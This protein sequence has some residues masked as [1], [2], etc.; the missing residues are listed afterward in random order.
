MCLP[1]H[2]S[3]QGKLVK[4]FY[5]IYPSSSSSSSSSTTKSSLSTTSSWKRR[6]PYHYYCYYLEVLSYDYISENDIIIIINIIIVIILSFIYSFHI[7]LIVKLF[8]PM[9]YFL[10]QLVFW[11]KKVCFSIVKKRNDYV[12]IE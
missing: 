8:V 4:S 2:K 5:L 9:S 7:N 10:A 11:R 3:S 1:L 6:H 12:K